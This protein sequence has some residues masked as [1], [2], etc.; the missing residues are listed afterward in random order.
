MLGSRTLNAI[1]FRS[2]SKQFFNM[3]LEMEEYMVGRKDASHWGHWN[4]FAT[5]G[6]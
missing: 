1:I 2:G 6:S 5:G 4:V 3:A